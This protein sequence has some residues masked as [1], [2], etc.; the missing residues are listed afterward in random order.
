MPS[1]PRG[2]RVSRVTVEGLKEASANLSRFL[3]TLESVPTQILLEEAPKIEETAKNRTPVA[4]TKLQNSVRVTVS[5]DKRR[6]GLYAQ[7]SAH[8][9]GYDYAYIQHENDAYDHPNGGKAHFVES[10]FTEGVER[11]IRRLSEEVRYDK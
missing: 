11:I 10:A 9:R 8:N 3:K 1:K 2:K 4:T 5:R 7:A 6:P